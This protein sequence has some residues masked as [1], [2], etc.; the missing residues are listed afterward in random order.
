MSHISIRH[1][2]FYHEWKPK[3]FCLHLLCLHSLSGS[4]CPCILK[5]DFY[6]FVFHD[7]VM[8]CL[9]IHVLILHFVPLELKILFIVNLLYLHHKAMVFL[10]WNSKVV[11]ANAIRPG[12]RLSCQLWYGSIQIQ[13]DI[14]TFAI[15]RQIEH[16]VRWNG[17]DHVDTWSTSLRRSM[18]C[19][20][21]SVMEGGRGM[22]GGERW[23]LMGLLFR[24]AGLGCH[25]GIAHPLPRQYCQLSCCYPWN[26]CPND[27]TWW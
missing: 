22:E 4:T 2:P 25:Q 12:G 24:C 13:V 16:G 15:V 26:S 21:L 6:L 20:R 8:D 17:G 27:Y 9:C 5:V 14:F 19:W 7:P 1:D 3:Y 10:H 11:R 18:R 23:W